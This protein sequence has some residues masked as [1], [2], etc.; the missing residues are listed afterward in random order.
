MG[1]MKTS[2]SAREEQQ[3]FQC[4]L[5][6][7]R[8]WIFTYKNFVTLTVLYNRFS[9]PK[10]NPSDPTEQVVLNLQNLQSTNQSTLT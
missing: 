1:M 2:H 5:F 10:K 6:V 7:L 3:I 9:R 4:S 8:H